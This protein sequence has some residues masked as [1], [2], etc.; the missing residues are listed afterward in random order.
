MKVLQTLRNWFGGQKDDAEAPAPDQRA[1]DGE[2]S[3][4]SPTPVELNYQAEHV[5][6]LLQ[7][8]RDD[9]RLAP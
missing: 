5:E 7:D 2:A 1:N 6:K 9:D 4:S 8:E 3:D